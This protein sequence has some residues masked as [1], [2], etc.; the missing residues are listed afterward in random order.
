MKIRITLYLFFGLFNSMFASGEWGPVGG[1][2]V[3]MGLSQVACTDLWSVNNN[4]AGMAFYD[5]T[6][7]GLYFEN[8]FLLKELGSQTAAFTLKTR[9]GVLGS[10]VGYSGDASYNTTRAGLA[11]SR[12]LGNRFSAGIQLDYISTRLGDE[13]GKK[14][15]VTFEAGI[16][17]KVTEQL[18]FGAH[19]FNP[20]HV[21]LSE[22]N[23]EYIPSTLNAGF[24]FTFS[25]KLLLTAEAD[26]NSGFPLE[27]HSGAEYK[28]G[29][30][31]YARVG[32]TTNPA[33]YT[34][35]FG[36]EMKNLSIDLSSSMHPQLC[37]SPQASVQY[38]F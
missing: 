2:S 20:V 25:D 10:S 32:L 33:R 13:Y 16:L 38:T 24:S 27:F 29:R 35:G 17:V 7:A 23:N 11:Y 22:Y 18:A 30:N 5:R 15:N 26:K 21:R 14:S 9:Y 6:A 1:R 3:A 28:L 4:Q 37:Y 34:F 12:K 19:A 36:L 31:A 8:R